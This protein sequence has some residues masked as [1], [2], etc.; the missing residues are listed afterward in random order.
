MKK[1][2]TFIEVV[3]PYDFRI[4]THSHRYKKYH[5]DEYDR[6]SDCYKRAFVS[7]GQLYLAEIRSND[8]IHTSGLAVDIIGKKISEESVEHI[9]NELRKQFLTPVDVKPFYRKTAKDKTLSSICKRYRGLKPN[10]PGDLFECLT[11]CIISQQINVTFADKVEMNY[12]RR[13]GKK[14][15]YH[16]EIFYTYPDPQTVADI[17]KKELLKIQFSERKADYLIDLAKSIVKKEVDL[18]QIESLP[19]EEFQK[20]ITTI[21]GIGRW[22][23]ECSLMH[24]G[25]RNILPRG[26]IGLHQAIRLFYKLDKRTEMDA[27]LKV[28]DNW[29]GWETFAVYYLWHAL[30]DARTKREELK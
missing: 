3:P 21:R 13:F 30:T 22:T 20:E 10:W 17:K 24:L 4:S 19:P 7:D 1:Y 2:S 11:R 8:G 28:A 29:K 27:L 26:D 15:A 14:L 5:Y 9:K 25:H 12:V 16:G 23:A 18:K 6:T